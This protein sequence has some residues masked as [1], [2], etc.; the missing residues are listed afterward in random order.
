MKD[1]EFRDTIERV[2]EK[3]DIVQVI[4]QRIKLDSHH[5]A[6][7]PFH[8][9]DI[10]SFSVN[11]RGQ[12]FHCFGCGVGGDAFKFLELYEN[13]PFMQILSELAQQ[14]DISISTI[15]P[16]DWQLIEEGR[17]IEDV[18]AETAKFY[19]QNLTEEVRDYLVKERGFTDETISHFLIG[20]ANGGLKEYLIDKRKFS[21]DLCLKSG[22]LKKEEKRGEGKI[23]RDYFHNRIIF[24]NL[25]Q[26]RVVHLSGRSI[27]GREPKYLHLPGE[28][29]H[30]YN[31][32]VLSNKIVYITEGAPDCISAVQTGY[33]TV[34]ILGT[35]FKPEYLPKFSQCEMIYLCFDGD[36]SGKEAALKIGEIIGERVRIV[37]LPEGLDLN[38]YLKNHT[39]EE[40][41]NLIASAKDIVKY[42]LSFI[43]SDIDKTELPSKLDPI[44]KQLARMERVKAEAYLNY[45]IKSHFKL[46]KA[47]TDGYRKL[48]NKYRKQESDIDKSRAS[49]TQTSNS[50]ASPVYIA[51]FDGLVDIVEH[52]GSPAF[53]VKDGDKLSILTQVE[54]NGVLYIPPSKEQIPWLLPRGEEILKLYGLE[55]V[56]PLA[57]SDGALYDDLLAYH[58]KISELPSEEYYDLIVAWDLH[59][60]LLESVQ[61]SPIICF[62]AV[63][64]RGKSR[65]GKG[66]IYVAYRGIHVESLRD[67]YIVRVANNFQASIFFDVSDIWRKAEKNGTEDILLHRFEKGAM[68]PR[69]LYPE[70]GAHQDTVYYSVFGPT[71]IATNEGIDH[72]L[73]TRTISITMPETSKQ[74]E[75]DV[76]PDLAL[77][78]KE[79]LV[80]FRARHFGES[81]T[82]IPKPA[83]SRLGDIL[84]PLQQ[85][86][87]LVKPEREASFLNLIKEL[88]SER[89]IEK[90]ISLE[91]QILKVVIN[92][93]DQV[94]NGILPVKTITDAFNGDKS[95]KSQI[96]YQRVG[97]R[98]T[99]MGFKKTKT[100]D[101]SSAIAWDEKK[102]ERLKEDYGL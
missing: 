31:E 77:P 84:K 22:V 99:A 91:A 23:V 2:K 102:I 74:F 72:I 81:L 42:K 11:P 24:P 100:S 51:L 40:F 46:K 49:N 89:K 98:L 70:R 63:P 92:L 83:K 61:Y 52:D 21:L 12:Y 65:T 56:L 94:A 3:V 96:T 17:K 43:P 66:M 75:N 60:Y 14:V 44:L 20:Y 67:A 38:D 53:L 26:G 87:H 62:F 32:D 55:E 86:I 25:K 9:E 79:R 8:T 78:L 16:K 10:P 34:A 5:K 6:L 68:V 101:N 93:E 76:K 95:G 18:R 29:H 33:S 27:D 57:E 15:T 97:R 82:D 59:T 50:Y 39:K 47:D 88:E 58:K 90:A 7:C 69:V 1:A 71:V 73:E 80:V 13:K 37:Q 19:Y 30:L 41:E 4:G 48:V 36:E 28:I 35:S 45:E 64:E 54:R 85:I